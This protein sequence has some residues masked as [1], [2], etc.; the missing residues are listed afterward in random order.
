MGSIPAGTRLGFSHAS[1]AG[2]FAMKLLISDTPPYFLDLDAP[3]LPAEPVTDDDGVEIW[4]VWC[5][6]FA[7]NLAQLCASSYN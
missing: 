3:T 7:Y 5:K 4:R 1:I 6:Q 2:R